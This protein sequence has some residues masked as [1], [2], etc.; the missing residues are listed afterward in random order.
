MYVPYNREW[1]WLPGNCKV[2]QLFDKNDIPV[3]W[4]DFEPSL[5]KAI[6]RMVNRVP[7]L[8]PGD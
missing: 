3:S 2:W 7:R 4:G 5:D 1:Y 6:V 8:I